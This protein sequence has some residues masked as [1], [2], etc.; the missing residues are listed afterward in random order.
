MMAIRGTLPVLPTPFLND[1][2]D[3]R[4]IERMLE[5]TLPYVDGYTLMGSTAEAPSMTLEE[6]M[7]T[8]EFILES[9]PADTCVVVGIASTSMADA[10]RLA[11]HA[12]AHGAKGV[13]L[14]VPY[15]FPNSADGALRF[16]AEVDKVLEIE[17]VLYDNPVTTKTTLAAQTVIS[18]SQQLA[19]LRT[20]KLTDHDVSKIAPWKGAGLSVLAGDDVILFRYLVA[21]VDGSMVL[22]PAI[23]PAAF[24]EVWEHVQQGNVDMAFAIFAE[25]ILPFLHVFGIGD[26]IA[27]TK[28]LYHDLALFASS[29]VRPPLTGV[30]PQRQG[31]LRLA[32]DL[33]GKRARQRR[34][35]AAD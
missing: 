26:E 29:D 31:L 14:P 8:A 33:A 15:Y 7:A 20:V 5:H 1:G 2:I 23:F 18:W 22:A 13:L 17:L 32:Y 30:D 11:R 35:P 6:R 21:G 28:A 10:V 3:H 25:E 34:S 4:S 9:V 19:H 16:L 12:Q 27:T 24:K